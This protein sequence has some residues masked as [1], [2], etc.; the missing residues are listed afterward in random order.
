MAHRGEW[1]G[2]KTVTLNLDINFIT[3]GGVWLHIAQVLPVLREKRKP[4]KI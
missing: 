1:V 4:E 3:K 2:G